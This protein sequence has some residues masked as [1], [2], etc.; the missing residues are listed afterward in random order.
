MDKAH[1]IVAVRML[2]AYAKIEA[3]NSCRKPNVG[4]VSAHI[5]G[6]HISKYVGAA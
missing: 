5:G 6:V 1:Q 4:H 3:G 2:R